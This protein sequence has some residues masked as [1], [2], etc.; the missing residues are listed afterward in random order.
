MWTYVLT[1]ST[2]ALFRLEN[3]ALADCAADAQTALEIQGQERWADNTTM[4][5]TAYASAL[6][7]RGET[8]RAEEALAAIKRPGFDRFVWEYHWYLMARGRLQLARGDLEGAL[9]TFLACG[10]SLGQAGLN[11]PVLT[12]WWLE[13]AC[14]LG[15]LGRT[16][17][18]R[19]L[20]EQGAA[21]SERWGTRRALGYAALARGA[22]TPGPGAVAPLRE[23]VT[24]LGSSPARGY[25]AR[26]S[27]MLGRALM[28]DGQARQAREHLRAA[29]AL[30]RRCGCVALARQARQDLL[31]AG[32]RMREIT[33]SALDMLTGTERTVAGLVASGAGNRE[34]AQSLFVT[35]RT[36]E[37]HL[38]SVYRKLGVRR[39]AD[40]GAAL[41]ADG[42]PCRAPARPAGDST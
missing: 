36:V 13:A 17:E 26:A 31:A 14:L 39:R 16:G 2:R 6:V 28:A 11:N 27:L 18:A 25:E 5:H 32:G 9:A 37:L 41:Q 20:A 42:A 12:P 8:A 40:L 15:Q 21:G 4:A 35:V 10:D 24:L 34:V 19:A 29:V 3:G 22:A 7:A 30:A 23:A 38:T 33:S 1:L